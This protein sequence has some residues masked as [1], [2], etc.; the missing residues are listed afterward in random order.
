MADVRWQ[1]SDVLSRTQT[2][3]ERP[4]ALQ[5][6]TPPPTQSK[7]FSAPARLLRSSNVCQPGLRLFACLRACTP[8]CLHAQNH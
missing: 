2:D 6:V 4:A 3:W 5:A 8:E 7:A 1:M